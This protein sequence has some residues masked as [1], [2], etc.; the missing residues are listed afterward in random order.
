MFFVSLRFGMGLA[1]HALMMIGERRARE[2]TDN[3]S[4]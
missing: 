4:D 1:M 3:H 2:K